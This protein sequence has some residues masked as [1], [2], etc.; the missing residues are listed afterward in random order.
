MRGWLRH[1]PPPPPVPAAGA[2]GAVASRPQIACDGKTQPGSRRGRPGALVMAA[3]VNVWA[4][5]EGLCMAQR[6]TPESGG[7]SPQLQLLL[8]H[9]QLKG[10]ILSAER[11]RRPLPA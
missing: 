1:I 5:E 4:V 8:K 10:V 9:L 6:R 11:R 7:E 3:T 2:N